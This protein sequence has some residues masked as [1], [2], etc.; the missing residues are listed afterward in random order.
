MLSTLE[1]ASVTK[2]LSLDSNL[3]EVVEAVAKG[4]IKPLAKGKGS[5]SGDAKAGSSGLPHDS[6]GRGPVTQE[7]DPPSK[8]SLGLFDSQL[9]FEDV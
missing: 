5:G 4:D 7:S 3:S 9:D 2:A 8:V 6:V 1:D